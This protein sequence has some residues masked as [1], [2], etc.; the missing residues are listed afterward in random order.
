MTRSLLLLCL[1]SIGVSGCVAR[2]RFVARCQW[3]SEAAASLDLRDQSQLRHLR[4]DA[5]IAEDLA[6]SYADSA[7]AS[8]RPG[9]HRRATE[10][11]EATLFGAIAHVHGVTPQQVTEALARQM[12]T[13]R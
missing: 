2:N 10:L 5:W 3:P 13:P 1:L 8:P 11:C 4:D 12:D 6:V 9:E 7:G